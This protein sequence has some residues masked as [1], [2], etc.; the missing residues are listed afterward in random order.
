M[1]PTLPLSTDTQTLFLSNVMK[2]KLSK[3]HFKTFRVFSC[4]KPPKKCKRLFAKLRK[5]DIW[6]P[7]KSHVHLTENIEKKMII[8]RKE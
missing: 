2:Q 4:L 6:F 3:G 8:Y 7:H 1:K 5:R